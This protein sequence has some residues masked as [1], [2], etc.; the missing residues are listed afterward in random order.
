MIAPLYRRSHIRILSKL[1]SEK[2]KELINAVDMRVVVKKNHDCGHNT[3]V[4]IDCY[5]PYLSRI[6]EEDYL[7]C[8]E[9]DKASPS[10][11]PSIDLPE[12]RLIRNSYKKHFGEKLRTYPLASAIYF[13]PP[14]PL[15][16]PRPRPSNL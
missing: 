8:G 16:L 11:S 9:R 5:L 14:P 2:L 15:P 1:C 6:A 13:T 7:C 4:C 10:P 12:I 3:S